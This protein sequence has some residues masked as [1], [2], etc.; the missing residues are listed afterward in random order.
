MLPDTYPKL[1]LIQQDYPVVQLFFF[2]IFRLLPAIIIYCR[3]MRTWSYQKKDDSAK[4][5][6][7]NRGK[8]ALLLY[9]NDEPSA[10]AAPGRQ[11]T[12]WSEARPLFPAQQYSWRTRTAVQ[13]AH[14][15]KVQLANQN[16][17]IHWYT[18]REVQLAHQN[19]SI[20]WYTRREVQLAHQNSCIVGAQE[21]QYSW[22]TRKKYSWRTKTAVQLAHQNSSTVGAPEQQ[23]SWHTR[24]K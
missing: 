20:H 5:P 7:L 9:L 14:Q 22:R 19:S 13:L 8:C 10:G 24:K 17:N 1:L 11:G 23:Y 6:R 12:N 21:Q 18:R 16:S 15:K 3:K 2:W 4:Y